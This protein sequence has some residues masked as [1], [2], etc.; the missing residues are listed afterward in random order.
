MTC[1]TDRSRPCLDFYGP[2]TA[3]GSSLSPAIHAALLARGG[4]PERALEL[5]RMAA[6]LDLDDRTG[7]TAEGLHLATMGGVWQALAFGFLGV[8]ADEGMLTVKPCL[9]EDWHVLG[10]RFRFRGRSLCVRAEHRLVT[11]TSSAAL[12]VQIG[13]QPPARLEAGTTDIPLSPT[14]RMS[15]P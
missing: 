3:H 9:P 2:R 10:L 14:P 13:D 5:F 6:R 8:K 12:L 15:H 7:T 1:T 4:Q 11:I